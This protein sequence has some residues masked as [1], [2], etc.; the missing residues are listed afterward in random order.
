MTFDAA[1]HREEILTIAA[2]YG[3]RNIRV[4]GSIA[5]GQASAESDLDL[6]VDLELG[7][8]LLDLG[9]FA[10]DLEERLGRRIDAQTTEGLHWSIRDQIVEEAVPL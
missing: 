6:L 10:M 7:R 3:V 1:G 9:G 8:S 4:F 5:S 2:R